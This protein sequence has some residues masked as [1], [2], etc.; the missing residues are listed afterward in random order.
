[1]E[2]ELLTIAL[3]VVGGGTVVWAVQGLRRFLKSGEEP[4][5][6]KLPEQKKPVTVEEP[7][8]EP[9]RPAQVPE[10]PAPQPPP[11]PEPPPIP[12][13][14]EAPVS[15][16]PR[17]FSHDLEDVPPT[18]MAKIDR[19]IVSPQPNALVVNAV[20]TGL[21]RPP[22]QPLSETGTWW[23]HCITGEYAG[24]SIEIPPEGVVIGRN[25][26]LAHLILS[27]PEISGHHTRI[28]A[29][30]KPSELLIL[31]DLHSMNGTRI[32]LSDGS[33]ADL[34]GSRTFTREEAHRLR[35]DLANG[36][37]EFEIETQ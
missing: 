2:L 12:T 31:E 15:S 11:R 3:M 27:D 34:E 20:S 26:A 8:A 1:M 23:L 14:R 9:T 24:Q 4:V 7:A 19:S 35:F 37:A 25:P 28:L 18:V 29:V 33:W 5:Q 22:V 6:Q 16:P 30:Q 32:R 36:V 21:I 10:N 13:H 17:A